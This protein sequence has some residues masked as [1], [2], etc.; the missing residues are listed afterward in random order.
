MDKCCTYGETQISQRRVNGLQLPFNYLQ[1]SSW[2]VFFV[3]AVL[4]FVFVVQIQF[5]ELKVI[6]YVLYT[7]LYTSHLISHVTALLLDPAE[8]ALRKL[9]KKYVPEFDRS[10]HAHVI[11]NGR[12]HLCNIFTSSK[13]T[14]HCS[15]C[16][17]CVYYF[18][19]HCKWLN[20][21]IGRRNYA[22]FMVCVVTATLI[23][24]LTACLC[25]T[26]VTLFLT[27]PHLLSI[28][29]QN[30][31]K[32]TALEKSG[33]NV[34]YCKTSIA[35]LMMLFFLFLCAV[36]IGCALIHLLCFHIYISILGVS[37]YEYITATGHIEPCRMRCSKTPVN[38]KLYI[39]SRETNLYSHNNR[40]ISKM[41]YAWRKK[42]NALN[43][44]KAQNNNSVATLVHIII[45]EEI[46]KAKK[47]LQEKNKIHP[48]EQT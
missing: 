16:N 12:C 44:L 14:K 19:H 45:H 39:A 9:R 20:N 35:F 30:F 5:Y 48:E 34:K 31:V 27:N 37:T 13:R 41:S 33:N 8:K 2:V 47:L 22:V 23:A 26:D 32:C 18:D 38:K 36:A 43:I 29:A 4:N 6:S 15:V 17:K 1:I 25:V 42:M 28:E 11:E 21:C 24:L 7:V 10:V 40:D 46:K 3:T